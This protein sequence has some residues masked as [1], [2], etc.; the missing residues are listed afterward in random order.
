MKNLKVIAFFLIASQA[1]ALIVWYTSVTQDIMSFLGLMQLR[2]ASL[3][4]IFGVTG[5]MNKDSI[6]HNAFG[7]QAS[8]VKIHENENKEPAS[9]FW[10]E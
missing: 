10:R 1:F 8:K 4:P 5:R 3:C 7:K 9:L 6:N 2:I